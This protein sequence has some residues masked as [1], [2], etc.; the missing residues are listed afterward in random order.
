VQIHCESESITVDLPGRRVELPEYVAAELQ[1]MWGYKQRRLPFFGGHPASITKQ[2][3]NEIFTSLNPLKQSPF[4]VCEKTDGVRYLLVIARV[5]Y[6]DLTRDVRPGEEAP[7]T[8]FFM[9]SRQGTGKL[10]AYAVQV[11]LSHLL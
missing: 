7:Y 6:K 2:T 5:S 10:V 8:E 9:V 1:S 4:L 3:C 11:A